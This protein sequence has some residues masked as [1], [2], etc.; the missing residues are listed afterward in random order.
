MARIL[1]HLHLYYHEQTDYFIEK[2]KNING[3]E[4]DLI[5]TYSTRD[6]VSAQKLQDF[7]PDV[8]MMEVENIGYDVWPFIK[9]AKETNLDNYDYVI[10]LHTKRSMG[11][12]RPNIIAFKGYDWRNALVDGILYSKEH[13]SKVLKMFEEDP[14]A[15][16]VSSLLTAVTRDYFHPEVEE[17][18]KRLG[19]EKKN[20]QTCMGT[21]FMI[22]S[23]ALNLLKDER[24][25]REI[26]EDDRP[27][28][29]TFFQKAHLYERMFSH[30]AI[31]SG[32]KFKTVCPKKKDYIKIKS[33]KAIEP[34]GKFFFTCQREGRYRQKVIRLFRIKLY[35]E[36]I[37]P[38]NYIRERSTGGA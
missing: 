11:K 16:M 37:D 31:N 19:W 23:K 27:L 10:K 20:R 22:R 14:S 15:G 1:V 26:F 28:S 30:L 24:I 33:N 32:L 2:L 4:W 12:C 6:E 36:K 34:L 18:L 3:V 25:G 35:K 5:V 8:K 38:A 7:K 17:E 29:G 13:F 21:M 9:V